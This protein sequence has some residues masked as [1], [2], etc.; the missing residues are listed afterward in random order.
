ME[1]CMRKWLIVTLLFIFIGCACN[2]VETTDKEVICVEDLKSEEIMRIVTLEPTI[3]PTESPKP[4]K[5]INIVKPTVKST[6]TPT[7]SPDPP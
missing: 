7:K 3:A 5:K 1:E 6:I 2:S 4:T